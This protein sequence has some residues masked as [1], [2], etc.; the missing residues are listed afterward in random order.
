[1]NLS[2]IMEYLL[3]KCIL[4]N[5]SDLHVKAGQLPYLRVAGKLV[6][7]SDRTVDSQTIAE[8]LSETLEPVDYKRF[9]DG[10]EVDY[11]ISFD[12]MRFRCN[13]YRDMNGCCVAIRMLS[14][15]VFS[16]EELRIPTILK[17][18]AIKKSGLI[19][20]TGTT[21][22]GKST[23]MTTILDYINENC[24]EHI[25]T[26]EDPIEYIHQI[27]KSIISQREIGKDS[28][29]FQPAIEA[30]MRE[31]PD[32]LMIGEIRD[33]GSVQA[34]IAAA[35]T[36]HLVIST[37]HTKGVENTVDRIIDMFP[38]DQQTQIRTQLSMTLL[39]VCSQQLLPG[40]IP[41][42]RYL[43]TEVMVCN[44]AVRNLIRTGKSQMISSTLKT[45][46]ADGMYTMKDSIDQLY[47]EGL[48][49]EE[50]KNV[51]TS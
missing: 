15:K 45:S 48:I 26:L 32:V 46:R 49:T 34:A 7:A 47:R 28:R 8:F 25:I 44:F 16:F 43:A 35:E 9:L 4:N 22:S 30:A 31:D 23:T 38:A 50:I 1:M 29:G 42:S 36:G 39:C 27:K 18:F 33:I 10:N 2:V 24:S 51:Y 14:Q 21:G 40:K 20:I 13:G 12:N 3:K 41:A 19:L 11:A 17:D 6:A 5:A 37:I